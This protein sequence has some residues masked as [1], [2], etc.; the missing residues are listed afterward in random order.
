MLLVII[1]VI[2]LAFR[3]WL[4]ELKLINE[5]QFRRR[6]LS[7]F[8]NYFACFSLIFG[9][10]SWFLNLIVMIAFP[11]LV[12]TPGWD[13]TFYRRFRN[14]NYWEKNRKWMLVERLTM[15]PPVILLGVVLLIVRARPFI[16]APNLLFILLAG[17]VLLSPFF[18]LDERWR[19]RYNWPQA[20]TVIGLMLS[21]TFAM[22]IAQ[23]LLWGV[24]LW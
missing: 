12:V 15:H 23:A 14:R 1:G 8:V 16:E 24:P 13:I 3:V 17:L 7:R 5:L 21:S 11:V 6:Y 22:M 19:T 9:L 2:F 20:P 18:I 10:S 4:V